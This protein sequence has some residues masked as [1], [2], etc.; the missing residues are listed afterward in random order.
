[1]LGKGRKPLLLPSAKP[2]S[3]PPFAALLF[4]SLLFQQGRCP[5]CC[6]RPVLPMLLAST[7]PPFLAPPCTLVSPTSPCLFGS[8]SSLD[9]SQQLSIT[10]KL[11]PHTHTKSQTNPPQLLFSLPCFLSLEKFLKVF[12]LI[13]FIISR[14]PRT[15]PTSNPASAS[16]T[17]KQLLV[18]VEL[19]QQL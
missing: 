18:A 10:L 6:P 17:P 14:L 11:F 3:L 9:P 1:M 5:P 4:P 16:H 8:P 2:T 12:S 7:P 19:I 15:L 13:A